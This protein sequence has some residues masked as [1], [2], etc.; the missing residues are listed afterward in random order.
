MSTLRVKLT[1]AVTKVEQRKNKRLARGV[2]IFFIAKIIN[3]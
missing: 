1:C 3:F 2:K